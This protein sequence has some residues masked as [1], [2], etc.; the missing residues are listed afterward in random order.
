MD[1]AGRR[2]YEAGGRDPGAVFG[3]ARRGAGRCESRLGARPRNRF[4][5][6]L[7]QGRTLEM[8]IDSL[9]T[10]RELI[11]DG[12]TY[13]YYSL[14]AAEDAGL[15]GIHR[16]PVSLKVLLENQLRFEDG[17]SVDEDDI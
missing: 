8:S 17:A 7:E 13:H 12:K 5:G 3:S 10:R 11:A 9:K 1:D 6:G 2:G 4:A 16:L 15:A 14:S